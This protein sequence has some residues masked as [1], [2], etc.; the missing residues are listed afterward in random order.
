MKP[1]RV[2]T[3]EELEILKPEFVNYLVTQGIPAEEW[4]KWKITDIEK[5]LMIIEN[6]SQFIFF[7]ITDK[8]KFLH[9][10]IQN[11]RQYIRCGVNEFEM[12]WFQYNTLYNENEDVFSET[13]KDK[14]DVVKGKKKYTFSKN[15]EVFLLL[16]DGYLLVKQQDEDFFANLFSAFFDA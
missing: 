8:T 14:F 9:K 2:L 7:S 13:N 3:N 6:F 4:E 5:N 15:E 10:F 16:E 11:G 12:L 1:Y